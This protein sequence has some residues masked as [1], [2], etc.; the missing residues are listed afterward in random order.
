VVTQDIALDQALRGLETALAEV[1]L[2]RAESIARSFYD[3]DDRTVYHRSDDSHWHA[4]GSLG[5][6]RADARA[7]LAAHRVLAALDSERLAAD[8]ARVRRD[9]LA[10]V[11]ERLGRLPASGPALAVIDDLM[12]EVDGDDPDA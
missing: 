6:L 3:P 5:A 1:S 4:V 2:P 7:L 9:T 8:Y 12:R 11:K 10:S